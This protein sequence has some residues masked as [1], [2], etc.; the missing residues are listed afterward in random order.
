MPL[1]ATFQGISAEFIAD[2]E[3]AIRRQVNPSTCLNEMQ[4]KY[5][6]PSY[7]ASGEA[8]RLPA[9]Q[10]IRA[11][12]KSVR[13][14]ARYKM[15]SNIELQNW[16]K[17]RLVTSADGFDSIPADSHAMV[18]LD[19]FDQE[20]EVTQRDGSKAKRPCTGFVFSSKALLI[21]MKEAVLQLRG[22]WDDTKDG[23]FSIPSQGSMLR[24]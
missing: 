3:D 10:K 2:I 20:V 14:S 17:E 23:A 24:T 8:S 11:K 6:K 4:V 22:S 15:E 18:V 21:L 16:A 5:A 19:I 13:G 12:M 1:P 7:L 9:V